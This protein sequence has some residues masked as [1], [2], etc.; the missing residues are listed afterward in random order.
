MNRAIQVLE[1]LETKLKERSADI[2]EALASGAAADY[3]AYQNLVGQARGLAAAQMEAN[4]LLRRLKEID[5]D[6]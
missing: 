1:H 6:D 5:N 3:A 4:D 2:G